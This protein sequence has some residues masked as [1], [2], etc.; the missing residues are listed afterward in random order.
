MEFIFLLGVIVVAAFVRDATRETEVSN[1]HD[2]VEGSRLH[3]G[4]F[5]GDAGDRGPREPGPLPRVG[6]VIPPKF[7]IVQTPPENSPPTPVVPEA[8]KTT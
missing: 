2:D 1:E 7:S 4:D 3:R 8:V 5:A 6:D